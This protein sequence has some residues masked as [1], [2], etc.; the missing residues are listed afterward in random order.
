MRS[1]LELGAR[2]PRVM[3]SPLLRLEAMMKK[4]LVLLKV[5]TST[6]RV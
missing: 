6:V 4:E 2:A 3:W 1:L 5:R